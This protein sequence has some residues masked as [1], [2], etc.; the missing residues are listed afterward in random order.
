MRESERGREWERKGEK[1]CKIG[2]AKGRERERSESISLLE[3]HS[4]SNR[5]REGGRA[6]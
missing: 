6:G 1:T 4:D 3:E 2:G 5:G